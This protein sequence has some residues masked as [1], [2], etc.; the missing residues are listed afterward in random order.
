MKNKIVLFDIDYTLFDTDAFKESSLTKFSLYREILPILESLVGIAELG[1]FSKGENE[2]QNNK[3]QQTGVSNFFQQEHV[4][5]FEDKDTNLKNI[6]EKYKDFKI[7]FVDDRLATLY[8]AKTINASVF[9]IWIKRGPFASD[10]SL[11]A[12]FS[13]D[14]VVDDLKEIL[15]VVS[16]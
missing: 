3:L 12:N 1:I 14:V 6:I 2:F 15:S 4:H 7:Y 9:T 11:L 8:N 13:P 5:V 16:G 10:E